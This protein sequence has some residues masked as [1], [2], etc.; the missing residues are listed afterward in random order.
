MQD[1]EVKTEK[2]DWQ[3]VFKA[4]WLPVLYWAVAV[5]LVSWLNAPGVGCLTPGGWLM[6]AMTGRRVKQYTRS[7]EPGTRV[8]E[9]ALGGVL[10]G[11]ALTVVFVLWS[12]GP[13]G[14]VESWDIEGA[15]INYFLLMGAALI[16]NLTIPVLFSVSTVNAKIVRRS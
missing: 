15:R 1:E 14:G 5:G 4:V 11:L 6:G 9:A 10:L 3:A 8:K 16:G 12:L 7:E 2:I 13:M